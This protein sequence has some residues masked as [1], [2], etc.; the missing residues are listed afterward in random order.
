MNEVD[1]YRQ[2]IEEGERAV[3]ES[4][5]AQGAYDQARRDVE[6]RYGTSDLDQLRARLHKL[7]EELRVKRKELEER[8]AELEGVMRGRP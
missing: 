4:A 6:A 2:L 7:Q 1:R 8:A 5:R 3:R